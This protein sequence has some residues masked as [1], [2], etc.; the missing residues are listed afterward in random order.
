MRRFIDQ[1]SRALVLYCA[2]LAAAYL[3][4]QFRCRKAAVHKTANRHSI[5][6]IPM[7]TSDS[8]PARFDVIVVG[9]GI[10]GLLL[11]LPLAR[12]RPDGA[13]VR[14]R[15]RG[16]RYL[17]LEPLPRLRA[18]TSRASSTLLVFDELQ[19]E[20]H[21]P[22]RYGTQPEILDTSTTSP[23]AST[24]AATSRSTR[25]SSPPLRQRRNTLDGH[26]GQRREPESR[27]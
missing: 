6:E 27:F 18:A 4:A 1:S 20:W 16:R 8:G 3:A 13:C 17:V 24:C 15:Q 21:W 5:W 11:A 23:T 10:S 12:A 19:Q 7:S 22:D 25:A 2:G 14:G 26:D 9:G